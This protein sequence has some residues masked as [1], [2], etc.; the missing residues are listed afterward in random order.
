MA[1]TAAALVIQ[2]SADFKDFKRQMQ[3]A[4]GVFDTEG[5]KIA[6]RQ[7]DLKKQL[8]N[9]TLDFTG[10]K[11]LNKAFV[12]LTAAGIVTGIGALVK[13]SLD[14][15]SAIGDISQQAGV[16]VEFLQ[17]MRFAAAQSGASFEI[18]DTALTTLNK[19]LGD[20][21]NTGAGKAE[22]TFKTLGIDKLIKSGDIR[23]A[24]DAFDAIAK[25]L[26]GFQSDAQK[27]SF[28]AATFGK[29]AGPKLLQLMNQ[30]TAGIAQLTH[31]AESLGIVLSTQTVRGAK[32]AS[33]KLDALFSVIKAQGVA[34]VASLAPE[35]AN[36]AQ[37][38][39]N[40]L[41]D[42]IT[43]VEKWAA[44]FNLIDL[45]PVQQAKIEIQGLATSLA[46]LE[47]Q[48]KATADNPN[49]FRALFGP[50][51]A[52]FDTLL[53]AEQAKLDAAKKKLDQLENHDLAGLTSKAISG[54]PLLF[55]PPKTA[56]LKINDIAGDKEAAAEAKRLEDLRLRRAQILQQTV[57]DT[58]T[59]QAALLAAQ[60]ETN[61]QLLK[62]T[63][64]YQAAVTKQIQDE[65]QSKIDVATAERD[66]TLAELNRQQKGWKDYGQ[67]VANINQELTDKV[68]AAAEERK[69]ALDAADPTGQAFREVLDV[70]KQQVNSLKDQAA[71]QYLV[72]RQL[73]QVLF[74]EQALAT[75]REKDPGFK[76]FSV[77]QSKQ[78]REQSNQIADSTTN[79]TDSFDK[80]QTDAYARIDDLRNRDLLSEQ[81]AAEAK[82][83]I[84]EELYAARLDAAAGFFSNLSVLSESSNKT[85]AAIGKAAAIAQ[86]T[87]DGILAVQKALASAPPPFNFIAAAAVGVA[88][89]ANVAKIAGIGFE[90]GGPTPQGPK[91]KAVGIVH[92][93]EDVWSQADIRRAGGIGVVEALR[94]GGARGYA[95]G[96]PVSVPTVM[97]SLPVVRLPS[98]S[99]NAPIFY[100]DARYATKGVSEEI[101]DQ[102]QST[103]PILV[104]A[105]VNESDKRF[106][107]NLSNTLRDKS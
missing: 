54:N 35:I 26:E 22:Q 5:R 100:I 65:F 34:A 85:L 9:W 18:M 90:A 38:I 43:W 57:V 45:S 3:S 47:Q 21:V 40:G 98:S 46:G 88:T 15:A 97:P 32:E 78:L 99:K 8:S 7:A 69:R 93:G 82:R 66:K 2:L 44:F 20:F 39:T 14:A 31:Q 70:G 103:Y 48:R 17:K 29:E 84:D 19:N 4:T 102:L 28:L 10:L 83:R 76:G 67:A 1:D 36:L 77:D 68:A 64:G 41:P 107:T 25:K 23:N 58:K 11:G 61:I 27:S 33:D 6:K 13:T 106:P 53:K 24:E 50:S 49:G 72:G 89:A 30:G 37:Q 71:A 79:P 101:H 52:E 55:A 75:A 87:I 92:A 74:L 16:S 63:E 56:S 86:A 73:A 60:N 96:G 95:A 51:L 42:L 104:R 59:S 80:Q 12:G 81:S 94:R 91:N 62:G 105:A